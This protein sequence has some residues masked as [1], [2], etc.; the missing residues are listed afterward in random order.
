MS[1]SCGPDLAQVL[2]RR[3]AARNRAPNDSNWFRNL[4]LSASLDDSDTYCVAAS[5]W[6]RTENGVTGR[7]PAWEAGMRRF[8]KR[9]A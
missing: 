2:F 5:K 4:D 6:G 8:D 7:R 1:C 9:L 3:P